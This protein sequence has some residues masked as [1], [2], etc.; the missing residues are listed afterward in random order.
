KLLFVLARS[1]KPMDF[2]QMCRRSNP[3][4]IP[5]RAPVRGADVSASRRPR[6][7]L[8]SEYFPSNPAVTVFGAFQRL[9]CHV[10]ALSKVGELDAVFFFPQNHQLS[11][12]E[13]KPY[14]GPVQSTWPIFGRLELISRQ[15]GPQV[16]GYRHP[17]RTLFWILRGAVSSFHFPSLRT[18]GPQTG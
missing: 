10:D 13:A 12:E 14:R 7:L 1:V 6:L 18:V 4:P 5:G 8:L 15:E 9:R 3:R 2:V 17:V 11:D 16:E